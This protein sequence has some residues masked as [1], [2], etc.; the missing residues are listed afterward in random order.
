[1]PFST[2]YFKEQTKNYIKEKYSKDIRILDIGAGAGTYYNLLKPIGFENIDAVE[3]FP[4]YVEKYLLR[5][6]YKNVFVGNV[7]EMEINFDDYDLVIL[8]DVLEHISHRDATSLLNK[9]KN[10]NVIIGVPFESPQGEHFGNVYETHLQEDLHLFNFIQRYPEY[11]PFCLRFDYGIFVLESNNKLYVEKDERPLPEDYLEFIKLNY[12]KLTLM[13]L[14]QNIVEKPIQHETTVVTALWNLGRGEITESFKRGYDDYRRK[15]GELLKTDIPMYIFV[16]E[17]DED[18]IW[19]IRER[20]NTVVNTMSLDELKKWFEFTDKTNE[21][22]L[23]ESWL[24]Q[25]AWLRESPQATLEG[26]NPLVMSKMFMLN[27]VTLWNPFSS[28][29]FFWIDAGITNTVHYGYFTHDKVF[30]NL[31]K[32]IESNKDFVFLTYPYEGGGEVHGF[33]RT[34]LASY[35]NTD[36]VKFVC[37]GGFFGGKKYRINELN[38][39]YYHNLKSSLSEGYMGTEESIFTI[40]MY[41]NPDI[42]TQYMIEG[43]GLVWP[44]FEDLKDKN[45][46]ERVVKSKE[47]LDVTKVAL[48][49]ITFNSPTQFRTLIESMVDYD[50]DFI[51]KTKKFLLDNSTDLSTTPEYK[52]LCDQYGFEHIKKDNIGIVG[53]RVFVA[54]HFD[55]L[56]LDF[57]FWFEDDM[58]FYTKKGDVCKNGFNRYVSNLYQKSLEIIQLENFDFLKLN[59]TEFYGDNSVQW[60]WYNVGQEFRES[61]W[62]NKPK[63]PKQ[64]LDPNTPK[65]KFEHIKI[66]KGLPYATGEIYLC[67]WPIVFTK[68]GNYKCYLETKWTFPYEQT[69]MSYCYQETVKGKIKPGILLLTPTEHNRFEFYDA[70]LRK[71]S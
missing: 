12:P 31:P 54:E 35:C 45:F 27:N 61:H 1:M 17:S 37:R 57:Y 47:K 48:Y 43:N 67:N 64:G 14:E 22:R 5:E 52:K 44:F 13:D 50:K 66:H 49:V 53:G 2:G 39:Q 63:L 18:F 55:Q 40:L 56:D 58:A 8:G 68:K 19:Q 46:S 62:P 70:S 15:F 29:Y 33:E 4:D 6:K 65:T 71:E 32:F 38:G 20:K 11:T 42:I 21:I 60:S 59:F 51:N 16:D 25:A 23:Q 3:V 41:N 30:N 24:S 69:L 28:E 34:A 9:I 36:Y 7:I 10:S 26:Y